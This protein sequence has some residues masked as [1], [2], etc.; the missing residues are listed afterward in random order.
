VLAIAACVAGCAFTVA[1]GAGLGGGQ[2]EYEVRATTI[3]GLGNVLADGTGHTLYLYV[4]DHQGPPTC[5]SFCA[6]QWPPLLLPNGVDKPKPGPGIRAAL[7][8]TVRLADGALQVTYNSWPLYLWQG[9]YTAG[10][11]TGQA[12]SMGLWY[13]VSIAGSIDRGVAS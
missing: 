11:A 1:C 7:L 8:G 3:S 6:V 10:Q 4:P 9:D 5:S 13:A 12:E 2:P